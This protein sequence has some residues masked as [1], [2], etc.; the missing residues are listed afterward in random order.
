ML[1]TTG[2][3]TDTVF[4]IPMLNSSFEEFYVLKRFKVEA[5][6]YGKILKG[7]ENMTDFLRY[8]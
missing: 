4:S 6:K 7:N 1:T 8:T 3:L 2:N 5:P